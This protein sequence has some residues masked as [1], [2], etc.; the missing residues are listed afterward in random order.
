MSDARPRRQGRVRIRTQ[1]SPASR[2]SGGSRTSDGVLFDPLSPSFLLDPYQVYT[3]LRQED[4]VHRHE[5]LGLWV[6]SRYENCRYVL[7]EDGLFAADPRRPRGDGLPGPEEAGTLAA[8]DRAPVRELLTHAFRTQDLGQL[9]ADVRE[10]TRERLAWLHSEGRE[11]A[12]FVSALAVPVASYAAGALFGGGLARWDGYLDACADAVRGMTAGATPEETDAGLRAR[13]LLGQMLRT[14]YRYAHGGSDRRGGL[15]RYLRL[16]EAEHSVGAEALTGSLGALLFAALNSGRRLLGNTLNALVRTPGALRGFAGLS[17][18]GTAV[19]LDELMRY[20][21]PFQAQD[22]TVTAATTLG[23]R[24]LAAGDRV[25]VLLGSA[26]RDPEAFPHPDRL[27]LSRS[28][29]PHFAFGV[30]PHSCLGVPLALLEARVL[31][32]EFAT[33][34]PDSTPVGDGTRE[35]HPT[36]RGFTALPVTLPH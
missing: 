1:E 11:E 26:H 7:Q 21:S 18:A 29:N 28:P 23:G 34:H 12:D 25:R 16:H 31:L 6:I 14:E 32:T 10:F 2:N 27:D 19:A 20:D 5:E 15:L 35:P 30:G 17:G 13:A 36:L 22:R 8:E 4:P 3:K 9:A 24:R 33:A